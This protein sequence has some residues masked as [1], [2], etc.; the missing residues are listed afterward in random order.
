MPLFQLNEKRFIDTEH[1]SVIHYTPANSNTIADPKLFQRT[2]SYLNIKLKSS[3]EIRL[4]GDEADEVW[5]AYQKAI[6]RPM[7]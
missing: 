5:A 7:R 2:P 6:R 1:I 3:E 4:E